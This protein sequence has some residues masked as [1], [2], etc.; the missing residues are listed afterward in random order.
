VDWPPESSVRLGSEG[1]PTFFGNP[2]EVQRMIARD[3]KEKVERILGDESVKICVE[4]GWGRSDSHLIQLAERNKANLIVVG[5]HQRLGLNRLRF[6]S[7][8]RGILHHAPMNVAVVPMPKTD[9]PSEKPIPEIR[10]VLVTTD[11]SDLGNGAVPYAYS[12]LVSGGTVHLV[13]VIPPFELPG[14]LV[15]H[16]QRRVVTK[17]GHAKAIVAARMQLRAL[18][19]KD[20]PR[21]IKTEIEVVESKNPANAIY[22]TAERV[23][24]DLI[25]MGSHG[26][27]G[28]SKAILGSVAEAVVAKSKRPVLILRPTKL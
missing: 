6:G 10:R 11:L 23:G 14:P 2:P 5:T 1:A 25:C 19:P 18:I 7:V 20:V 15:P 13:H 4:S 17:K 8:S 27:S 3:L 26:R 9:A 24:A 21:S 12:N 28:I 16:Y 22:K